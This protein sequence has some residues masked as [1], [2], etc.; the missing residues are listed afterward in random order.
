MGIV[1]YWTT[2]NLAYARRWFP[3]PCF[4]SGFAPPYFP[5]T[6]CFMPSYIKPATRNIVPSAARFSR[7]APTMSNTV[8]IAGGAL[9]ANKPPSVCEKCAA[10]LRSRGKK[11]LVS[12]GLADAVLQG[13]YVHT[14]TLKTALQA[15]NKY[16]KLTH[17]EAGARCHLLA[18]AP[19]FFLFII[20]L[21]CFEELYF[22]LP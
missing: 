22:Y 13:Q 11:S 4:A 21:Y 10:R 16:L 19:Q 14:K 15:R 18:A 17:K 3:T 2:G 20:H 9:S 5:P 12:C 1:F 6:S 7:P 8:R